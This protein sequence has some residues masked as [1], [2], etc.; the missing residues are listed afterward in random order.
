MVDEDELVAYLETTVENL[1]FYGRLGFEVVGEIVIHPSAPREYSLMRSRRS[2][3]EG[4]P[5][6]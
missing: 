6:P 3:R 5:R 1:G 2:V 4:S